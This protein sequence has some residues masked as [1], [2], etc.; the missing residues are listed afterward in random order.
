MNNFEREDF[1]VVPI[2]DSKKFNKIP[3]YDG[4]TIQWSNPDNWVSWQEREDFYPDCPDWYVIPP[5]YA[6]YSK[7]GMEIGFYVLDIDNH[8][9]DKFKEAI[10]ELRTWD[11]PPTLTV[12]TASGGLHLYYWTFADL[13]PLPQNDRNSKGLPIEIKV[14][15][16]WVAPNG[17]DRKVIRDL[18][19][20]QLFPIQGTKFGDFAFYKRKMKIRKTRKPINPN[21]QLPPIP[22]YPESHR[23]DSLI[24][25]IKALQDDGCPPDLV[26][27]YA[28]QAVE[29]SPGSRTIT[30]REINDMISWEGSGTD[31]QI[32]VERNKKDLNQLITEHA[33]QAHESPSKVPQPSELDKF[34][35]QKETALTEP[36]MSS[37]DI[38][39]LLHL[40]PLDPLEE[41]EAQAVFSTEEEKVELRKKYIEIKKS[42]VQ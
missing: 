22:T 39:E 26:E 1:M 38:V 9:G 30:R 32:L 5:N 17:R 29:N 31:N 8:E 4:H 10:E 13:L 19:V 28:L 27:Q 14:H 37:Q 18:P 2:Q 25:D 42:M 12:K 7:D 34:T 33:L 3:N 15:T 21:Y 23:H 24:K 36:L 20:A 6:K 16:G 11:L 41:L 40:E 35:S